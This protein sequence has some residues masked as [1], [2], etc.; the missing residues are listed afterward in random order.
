MQLDLGHFALSGL[1]MDLLIIL[2]TL[3]VRNLVFFT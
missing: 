2:L 3:V 1:I